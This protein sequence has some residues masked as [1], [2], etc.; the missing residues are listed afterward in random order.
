MD[1]RHRIVERRSSRLSPLNAHYTPPVGIN[2]M[3]Q[4]AGQ[5]GFQVGRI[6]EPAC[7]VGHFV[8]L[9]PEDM[10]RRSTVTA[11][12][13]D[14]VTARIAKAVYP[15]TDVR[16]QPFIWRVRKSNRSNRSAGTCRK[17]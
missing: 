3:Y 14:P 8:K 12:E 17:C 13:I 6:L 7:G 16:E 1:E 2:A 11:I 4:S 9:M 10:L 15:D 5:F